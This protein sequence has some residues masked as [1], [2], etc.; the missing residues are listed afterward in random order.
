M[1]NYFKSGV[2]NANCDVCGRKFKSDQLLP[3]WDSLMVCKDDWEARHP[4]DFLRI[5]E[6]KISAEWVRH[7]DD[8]F[9]N[10]P[11]CS[12]AGISSIAGYAVAGCSRPSTALPT[13]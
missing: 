12:T 3:R 6:E 7:Q 13:Q 8:V 10:T 4:M 11:Q 9:I 2:W 1:R 5:R